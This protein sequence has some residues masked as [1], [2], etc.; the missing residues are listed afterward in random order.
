M[1]VFPSLPSFNGLDFAQD[2][3][4]RDKENMNITFSIGTKL[5]NRIGLAL[6]NQTV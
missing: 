3:H 5:G 6:K 4:S 2:I 1:A